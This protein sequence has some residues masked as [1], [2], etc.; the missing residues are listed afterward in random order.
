MAK[1]WIKCQNYLGKQRNNIF[2]ID[3]QLFLWLA[4]EVKGVL[5]F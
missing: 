5:Q 4:T 1:N 2:V 3:F